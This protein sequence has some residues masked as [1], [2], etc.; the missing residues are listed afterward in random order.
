MPL[1]VGIPAALLS[2]LQC[3]HDIRST[4]GTTTNHQ[5]AKILS[6]SMKMLLWFIAAV[7]ITL[8][9]G[10]LPAAWLFVLLYLRFQHGSGLVAALLLS[11]GFVATLY[12]LVSVLLEIELLNGV[13][14]DFTRYI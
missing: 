8:A 12:L 13:I 5:E 1:V 14:V 11:S 6:P 4:P 7:L 10:I 2:L 3:W 9:L